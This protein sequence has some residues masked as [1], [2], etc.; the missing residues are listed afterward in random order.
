MAREI[1]SA[2]PG[3][4]KMRLMSSFRES[5]Y[6]SKSFD[7]FNSSLKEITFAIQSPEVVRLVEEI[8]GFAN[9]IPDPSLYAGG[10]SMMLSGNFLNPHIDNSYEQDR[11]Y[12]RTLNFLYYITPDWKES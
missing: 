8:T 11:L 7:G 10:L 1:H 5:K 9:Q 3:H 6:T 4:E 12:Y 2:F